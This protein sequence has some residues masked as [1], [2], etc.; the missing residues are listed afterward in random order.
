MNRTLALLPLLFILAPP[1]QSQAPGPTPTEA[2]ISGKVVDSKGL[3][4]SGA[5]VSAYGFN[6]AGPVPGTITGAD[7][8]FSLKSQPFGK[9]IVT[10]FKKDAGFPDAEMALYG[11]WAY[12]SVAPIDATPGAN[13]Q[14]NLQF[15]EPD[16]LIEWTVISKSGR[17]PISRASYEIEWVDDPH[18]MAR[19]SIAAD[20]FFRFVLP[21]HAVVI[22][23]QA[24]GFKDWAS[25]DA[26]AF[27]Q[28]LVLKPGTVDRRSIM[29][30]PK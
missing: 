17:A 21:K 24:P 13:I 1:S 8:S 19:S 28:P 23:I 20:G 22:H 10:A 7:G 5:N 16:A 29:L 14:V 30:D 15:S 18:I 12:P 9:G 4:V 2:I 25:T 6:W 3:P 26:S 11:H 27:G